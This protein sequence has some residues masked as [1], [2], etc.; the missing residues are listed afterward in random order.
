[1]P[2]TPSDGI[3][4]DPGIV[5]FNHAAVAPWP[6]RTVEAVKRFAEENGRR[7]AAAYPQWL[8]VEHRLRVHL[9]RLINAPLAEDV[10]LVKNTSE[11]LSMVAYGLDWRPGDNLVIFQGEFPSN[12]IV[13]ESLSAR[14]VEVRQVPLDGHSPSPEDD[15]LAACDRRTRLISLSSVQYAT[16]F[17]SDLARVGA[18]CRDQGVLFCVDAIQ[19]LGAVPFDVQ[20]VGADFVAADGHKWLLG[21]EGLGLFYCRAE[22]RE[23]IALHEFGWHMVDSPGDYDQQ[24]WR[25]AQTAMRFECGS[26]NMLGAHALE[27]SLGFIHEAGM[28]R[29]YNN[30]IRNTAYIFEKIE[31]NRLL[32]LLSPAAP[33]RRSGIVTF[34]MKGADSR[35][36]HHFLMENGVICAARGGGV[37]FSPH[38][39]NGPRDIDAALEILSRFERTSGR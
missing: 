6:V 11:A 30:I 36:L 33:S 3:A 24:T 35:V 15:L 31:E 32:E 28:E 39:Y 25:P 23:R 7:G 22:L 5:Y 20:A 4:I 16:G 19:S 26:P 13:W 34:R 1:M 14:G 18:F 17:R 38:F 29:I 21:P 8:D 10:A 27:A 12:R 37:R 2:P 9:A